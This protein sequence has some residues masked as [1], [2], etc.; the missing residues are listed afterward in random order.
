M[1]RVL[2]FSTGSSGIRASMTGI[3][4]LRSQHSLSFRGG[5]EIDPMTVSF[6]EGDAAARAF[7]YGGGVHKMQMDRF[8]KLNTADR[9]SFTRAIALEARGTWCGA[10]PLR[11]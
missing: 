1:N 11:A 6:W 7:A 3:A 4:G 2:D 8:R 9:S 10:N 5:L